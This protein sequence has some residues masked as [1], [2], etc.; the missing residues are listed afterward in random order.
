MFRAHLAVVSAEGLDE[1][2][3]GLSGGWFVTCD[4]VCAYR[5]DLY[6]V[7]TRRYE[8]AALECPARLVDISTG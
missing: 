3:N 5:A 1:G 8:L 6:L 2:V 4:M 7:M